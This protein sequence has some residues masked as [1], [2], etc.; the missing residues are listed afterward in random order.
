M[1]YEVYLYTLP[2]ISGDGKSIPG[3]D[4]KRQEFTSVDEA[5]SFASENKDKFDRV[6][7]MERNDDGQK[8][9]ERYWDGKPA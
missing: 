4:S 9:V 6:I 2:R 8:M 3:P 7:L 1:A 5:R